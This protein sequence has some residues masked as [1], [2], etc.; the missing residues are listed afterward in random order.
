MI[1]SNAKSTGKKWGKESVVSL[2]FI[3]ISSFE[4]A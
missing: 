1:K 3:T 4:V 2:S